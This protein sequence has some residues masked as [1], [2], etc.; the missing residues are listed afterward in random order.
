MC[1]ATRGP[2]KSRQTPSGSDRP[3]LLQTS[4]SPTG[5]A[6]HHRP[7]QP[8]S[9]GS[10]DASALALPL[11]YCESLGKVTS[12]CF[13]PRFLLCHLDRTPEVPPNPQAAVRIS[14]GEAHKEERVVVRG[15][16]S[17]SSSPEGPC[18]GKPWRHR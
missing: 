2:S 1:P 15:L 9:P 10:G 13:G 14:L 6:V 18:T 17:C 7:V 3:H 11:T 4:D 8:P 5:M 16:G 12:M